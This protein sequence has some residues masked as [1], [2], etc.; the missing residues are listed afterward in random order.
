MVTVNDTRSQPEHASAAT[1]LSS[2]R[3]EK[4]SRDLLMFAAA[5]MSFAAMVW[6]A[7]YWSL[8]TRL[9]TAIPFGYQLV[10]ALS[11]LVYSRTKNF[12]FLRVSQLALF[13]FIPFV[14]Q[15]AIGSFVSSSGVMLWAIMAPI[16]ALIF[17]GQ[18]E[19]LPWIVAYLI[20]TGVSG[21]FDYFLADAQPVL[22]MKT[23]AIFFV[24]NFAAISTMVYFLVRHFI[25]EQ[26]AHRAAVQA[27]H[28]LLE[29][30]QHRSERLLLNVLPKPVAER[31]KREEKTIADG[32]ADVSVMFADLVGF[33]KLSE[34]L[35]PNRVVALLN[36]VFSSFD[37]LA[38]R[39][40]L[41]KIKTIGDAYMA[42]G[43]LSNVVAD[44][45][46]A[47]A[48]DMALEMCEGIGRFA[49][50]HGHLMQIRI[51]I[52]TGP[53]VAGV[54]GTRKF[55]YDVWGDTVNIASRIHNEA[56]VNSI[57]VDTTTYK[58]LYTR[59][60]FAEPL[61]ITPKGK[62]ELKVYRLLGR[63]TPMLDVAPGA[64]QM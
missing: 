15:W 2:Q 10:S 48:A 58:R 18:R 16:G 9:S 22:P 57:L 24:L 27:Q 44:D 40:G 1:T 64:I 41:E 46:V 36:E 3:E 61:A 47:A 60:Q 19:S 39:H 21:V 50:A 37:E 49:S 6:L 63:G 29:A 38:E 23:V 17:W 59:Y 30:E 33:T 14:M 4:L 35:S 20:L 45:Y 13:L 43:G 31:L 54:I 7:I 51:G 52:A 62:S 32:F 34:E 42:A 5:L 12:A 25:Q 56:T 8:G 55:S 11:L 53:V 26:A 28:T